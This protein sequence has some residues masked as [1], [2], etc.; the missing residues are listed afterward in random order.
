MSAR[1]GIVVIGRNEGDRLGACLAAALE[2][3][4]PVIYADSASSDGSVGRAQAVGATVV[5]LD[6]ARP[7]NAAR[8]RR[9]GAE[10]LFADHPAIDYVQF[11]DGDCIV[12]S[13][14][15]D[16][17][18]AFLD[19]HADV[20]AVCGRRFEA[21]P[22]A[23]FYNRLCDAEWNT[24]VGEVAAVGG[25]ALMRASAYRAVGGFDPSILAGEEPELCD[26]LRAAG[27]KIW[28]I[29]A[30]MTEHDMAMTSLNQWLARS[31][32]GGIGYAQ[33]WRLTRGRL[34]ARQ[35]RSALLWVIG[36]PSVGLALAV[37]GGWPWLIMIP[38]IYAVQT[39][40][41]AGRHAIGER[42]AWQEA[43]LTMLGK[44]G[45]AAGAFSAL[46]LPDRIRRLAQG[47]S[48]DGGS[49]ITFGFGEAALMCLVAAAVACLVAWRSLAG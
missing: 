43:G 37:I 2:G 29:D 4:M 28:R 8:G 9:E 5:V 18:R 41:L 25:D 10:R 3:G 21:F 31:R 12:Q 47:D 13:G 35:L 20:A 6:P 45:E 42:A 33:V 23:S 44:G 16:A 14:W 26:R 39:T 36:V 38:L 32:R 24:P 15:I 17:A 7:M 30:P 48:A 19:D 22:E 27:W 34:F 11:L 49:G 1:V 40:R 46:I